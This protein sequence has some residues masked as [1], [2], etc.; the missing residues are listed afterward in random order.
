MK[1]DGLDNRIKQ[2]LKESADNVT[3]SA[4]LKTK[5]E[6][7]MK[8]EQGVSSMKRWTVK[9]AVT[10]AAVVCFMIPGAIFAGGKIA[11]YETSYN[12]AI[13]AH[14]DKWEDIEAFEKKAGVELELPKVLPGGYT[15]S[16]VQ[17]LSYV[18]K[19]SA[20]VVVAE[21]TE[22]D[23]TYKTKDGRK[24]NIS[25][26]KKEEKEE[27]D[28]MRIPDRELEKNGVSIG[29]YKDIYKFVPADYK[30]T[31]EDKKREE[32]GNYYVSYSSDKEEIKTFSYVY[33]EKDGQT[34]NIYTFDDEITSRELFRVAEEIVK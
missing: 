6:A 19:D 8:K 4:Y 5:I 21:G 20:K 25:V 17:N 15:F 29:Y 14:S 27:Q 26:Q 16:E 28:Q 10:V 7:E 9:R 11:S 23:V 32:K 13:D 34:I 30:L 12:P 3:P 31:E 22:L 18:G 2:S 33:W 24:L 1:N